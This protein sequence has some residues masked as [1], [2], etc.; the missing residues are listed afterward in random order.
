MDLP[1]DAVLERPSITTIATVIRAL[2]GGS[3]SRLVLCSDGHLYVLKTH[4]SPQGPN[5]LANEA[6]GSILLRGL[7]LP[8]PSWKPIRIDLKAVKFFPDLAT[9]TSAGTIQFPACGLH[10][11]SQYLGGTD[12][13]VFDFIP[14]SRL[15]GSMMASQLLGIRLFDIWANHQDERQ[16][17]F[18]RPKGAPTYAMH[19][20]DNG[21]LFGGPRWC[22]PAHNQLRLHSRPHSPIVPGDPEVE[23]WLQLFESRIPSLLR[24]AVAITPR[25][26][27]V[28]NIDSL[29][30]HLMRRLSSIRRFIS[31][32]AW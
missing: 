9:T 6:I 4:P 10:F 19:F 17:V 5:V 29:H 14:D 16:R 2:R 11:G 26:W 15:D 21:H 22:E 27:Y 24:Y 31:P 32:E 30:G 23:Y 12:H 25:E 1:V 20:I 8:A 18:L 3:Q 13:T 7:G 28:D